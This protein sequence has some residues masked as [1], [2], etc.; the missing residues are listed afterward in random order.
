[1][2]LS[3]HGYEDNRNAYYYLSA[4]SDLDRL[5]TTTVEGTVLLDILRQAFGKMI[6]FLDTCHAGLA[7]GS[8]ME[9]GAPNV[10]RLINELTSAENGIVAFA[11]SSGRIPSYEDPSWTNGAFTIAMIEGIGTRGH[12]GKAD[13]M[14]QGVITVALLDAW[15]SSRV[16]QLTRGA[17]APVAIRPI[18]DFAMFVPIQ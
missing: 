17:Q 13:M 15:I 5:H 7:V 16:K 4:D 14:G 11:S 12:K 9:K 18:P 3:G 8:S 1:V 2:F 10:S 6:V